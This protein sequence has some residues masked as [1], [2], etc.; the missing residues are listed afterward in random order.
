M[1]RGRGERRGRKDGRK[2]GKKLTN[3]FYLVHTDTSSCIM[4]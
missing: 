4:Y 1:E 2:E 3:I